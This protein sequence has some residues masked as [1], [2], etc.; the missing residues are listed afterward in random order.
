VHS[1]HTSSRVDAQPKE[2]L[3]IFLLQVETSVVKIATLLLEGRGMGSGSNG[4][5]PS[6]LFQMDKHPSS[7]APAPI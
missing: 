4:Q 1:I 5:A 7:E 2:G 3:C 6:P